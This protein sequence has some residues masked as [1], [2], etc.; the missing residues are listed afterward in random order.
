TALGNEYTPTAEVLDE[1]AF[2]NGIVGLHATGG[3]PKH[4]LPLLPLARAAG[5]VLGLGDFAA[6]PQGTPLLARGYSD[7]SAHG[8]LIHAAGGLGFMIGELLEAGLVHESV[9]TVAGDGLR[10]Y[11]QEPKLDAA[12]DLYWTDVT[13]K[14]LDDKILRPAADPFQPTGGLKKL[15]GNL[16]T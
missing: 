11:A 12:G 5:G 9:R 6:L 7:G 3:S 14:S 13:R 10:R 15:S 16:G 1:R 2:V 8:N 4:A